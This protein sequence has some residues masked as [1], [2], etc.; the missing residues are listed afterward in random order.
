MEGITKG[1]QRAL[2][3]LRVAM[4]Y[5]FFFAGSEKFLDLAGS[6]K[7]FTAAGFLKFGTLGTWPGTDPKVVVNPTHGFWV[8]LAGNA[9]LMSIIDTLVVFGELAIGIALI[10]GVATRFA[11]LMGTI[12]LSLFFVASWNFSTGI[13]NEQLGFALTTGV[14]GILGAGRYYGVDAVIEKLDRVKAIPAARYVL[15]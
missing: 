10:L 11:S 4:G 14:L 9:G 7:A 15:G 2:A 5:V 6:G 13:V 8:S 12:M 3:L 1:Q